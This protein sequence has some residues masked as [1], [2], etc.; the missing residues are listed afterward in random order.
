[1][2]EAKQP[3]TGRGND[4]SLALDDAAKQVPTGALGPYKVDLVVE[5]GNPKITEYKVTITPVEQ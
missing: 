2:E 4:L 5:V 1:M 3:K